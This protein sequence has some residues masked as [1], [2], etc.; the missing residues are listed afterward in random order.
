MKNQ[1]KQ[2]ERLLTLTQVLV[3]RFPDMD[4]SVDFQVKH[5]SFYLWEN[6]EI[7]KLEVCSL[8]K[9]DQ[10]IMEVAKEMYLLQKELENE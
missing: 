4:I 3:R 7:E 8:E 5:I 10:E 1:I 2:N 9:T 6:G